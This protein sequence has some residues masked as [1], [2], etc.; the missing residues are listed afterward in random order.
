VNKKNSFGKNERIKSKKVISALFDRSSAANRSFLIYPFKVIFSAKHTESTN[1]LLAEILISVSKKKFKN[2]TDRNLIKRR[3]KEAYRTNKLAFDM[4]ISVAL[5]YVANEIL[6]FG[7]IEKSIKN[8]L[9]RLEK[10]TG[11]KTS[12]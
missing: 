5:I 1:N 10:E 11:N 8:V 6:D 9:M 12:N 2:A 7:P 4:P 3:T